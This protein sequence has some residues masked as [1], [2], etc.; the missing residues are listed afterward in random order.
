ME[1]AIPDL[2]QWVTRFLLPLF[3]VSAFFMVVPLIG[4]QLVPVRV[5]LGFAIAITLVI[6]PLLPPLPPID[7]DKP[8]GE[9]PPPDGGTH[10]PDGNTVVEPPKDPQPQ[11]QPEPLPQPDPEPQPEHKPEPPPE[12]QPQPVETVGSNDAPPADD[13]FNFV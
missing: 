2:T 12:P 6:I 4:T 5:R 8:D 13:G 10:I 3:R 11:P 1:Y 7:G 9:L